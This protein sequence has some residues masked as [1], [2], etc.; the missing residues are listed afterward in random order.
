M[1]LVIEI[2]SVQVNAG[3]RGVLKAASLHACAGKVTALIGRNG[4]GK[5]TLLEAGLGIRPANHRVVRLSG[6][7]YPRPTLARLARA[8]LFYLPA[9]DLLDPSLPLG[10][11]LAAVIRHFAGPRLEQLQGELHLDAIISA[12]PVALSGGELRRAEV[13]LALARRPTCLV[14]DEP[15]RGLSPLDGDLI[16]RALRQRADEGAAVVVT[17]HEIPRLQGM[18]DAVCWCTAGTTREFP[19]AA[20]AWREPQ[21]LREFLGIAA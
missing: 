14:A 20:A 7:W 1:T 9:H 10:R 21:L 12:K 17:G 2:D 5:T 18:A 11:Q 19:S 6:R 16:E 13:A 15:F 4:A 8:G 3:G